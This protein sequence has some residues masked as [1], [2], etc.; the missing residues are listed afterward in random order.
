MSEKY[1]I[2]HSGSMS[3][4]KDADGRIVAD[5]HHKNHAELAQS[6]IAGQRA[7]E[8]CREVADD[9]EGTFSPVELET[10]ET[11]IGGY[12]DR[13]RAALASL[14]PEGGTR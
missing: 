9:I 2:E 6:F 11:L 13:L 1:R 14:S 4:V 3:T 5:F 10:S 7:V 12:R 8:A